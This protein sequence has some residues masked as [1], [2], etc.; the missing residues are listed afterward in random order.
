M[1]D[2]MVRNRCDPQSPSRCSEQREPFSWLPRTPIIYIIEARL[3]TSTL[4][5]CVVE[6]RK[7]KPLHTKKSHEW[8]VTVTGKDI[9]VLSREPP[10]RAWSR[11]AFHI[12]VHS[13]TA[14]YGRGHA[15][16]SI[17]GS[18]A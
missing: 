18:R 10:F 8:N 15:P 4:F 3:Y 9:L 13:V 5:F 6:W 11:I 1:C 17:F 2:T 7:K 16:L 12:R 14:V